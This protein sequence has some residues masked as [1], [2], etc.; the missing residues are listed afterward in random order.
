MSDETCEPMSCDALGY[1]CGMTND[2]CGSVDCGSCPGDQTCTNGQ[3]EPSRVDNPFAGTE[4]Y[5]N[6]D[7]AENVDL[8]IAQ[9]PELTAAMEA[10]KQQPTAV[11][12]Y[13]IAAIDPTADR[14]GLR[15]HFDEALAQQQA[16]GGGPMTVVLVVYDLPNR[17]C[18]AAASNGELLGDEGMQ[19]YRTEF[20]DRIAS[21]IE[22]DPQYQKLRVV[23]VLE[24]DSLPNIVTNLGLPSCVEAEPY[25]REGI[26]YAISRF[27]QIDNV[28]TYLDIAHSG[29]LGWEHP[30][31]AALIYQDVIDSAQPSRVSGFVT[32]VSNY[33]TLEESF[34][35]ED[36]AHDD[37]IQEYYEWNRI[38]DEQRYVARL[39][40]LFPTMG[41]VIDTG[42]NGWDP[43]T[44]PLEQ[45]THRGSWCN[46]GDAGIGERPQAEPQPGADYLHAYF[47]VKPPGES[48]GTSDESATDPN[49]EGKSF[50]EMCAAG[51]NDSMD[52]DA[53]H[54]G[55]WFHENF[56]ML[57]QNA[58]PPL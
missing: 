34:D 42:R 13:R 47:W 41:F 53:P 52:T 49:E 43:G 33:S 9:S 24:P 6:P 25:Y 2:A 58:T 31:S 15:Q 51:M 37:L 18:A 55:R 19:R 12:L 14:L 44:I 16:A 22:A 21:E 32:N 45:R 38:V 56:V 54:A 28:Y 35:P 46:V 20:I 1:E 57:V 30:E 11:W 39:S 36:Q 40:S 8:S 27:S 5:I 29:W 50:D 3:C 7:Y 23:T 17:D 26:S 10:V 4:F 48:D